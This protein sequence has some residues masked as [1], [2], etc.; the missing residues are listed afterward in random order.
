[1]FFYLEILS[2]KLWFGICRVFGFDSYLERLV[3][4]NDRLWLYK[5]LFVC[6]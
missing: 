6:M 3:V 5:C 1:M 2:G 4:L